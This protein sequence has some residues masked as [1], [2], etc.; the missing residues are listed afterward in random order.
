MHNENKT[1]RNKQKTLLGLKNG[2]SNLNGDTKMQRVLS[3]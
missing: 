3:K 2:N 1:Q